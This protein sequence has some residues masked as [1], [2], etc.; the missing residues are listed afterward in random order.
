MVAKKH[1]LGFGYIPDETKHHF[2]VITAPSPKNPIL[3][4]ER[5][6][7]DDAEKQIT[8]IN[9]NN[10]KVVID[11]HKWDLVKEP[12]QQEFNNRLKEKNT[13]VGKF[14]IGEVPVERLLGKET[15]ASFLML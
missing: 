3:I 13:I 11:R 14:K 1:A 15:Q 6:H 4:Y 7:W 10:L 2:L 5:F 9:E 12:L 8:D